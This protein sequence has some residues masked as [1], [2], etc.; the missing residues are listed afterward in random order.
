MIIS[1]ILGIW[2]HVLI[3]GVY[4]SDVRMFWP[5]N[6]VWLWQMLHEHTTKGQIETI[7][8]LFFI[9]AFVVYILA[10]TVFRRNWVRDNK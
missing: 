5:S 2:L 7:C 3:D 8:M 9:A 6:N 10:V 4:H 1:G